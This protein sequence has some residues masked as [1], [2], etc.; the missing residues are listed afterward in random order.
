M[1]AVAI[2]VVLLESFYWAGLTAAGRE[3]HPL[4]RS[5]EYL[6][7]IAALAVS[8]AT[9]VFGTLQGWRYFRTGESWSKT[10]SWIGMISLLMNVSWIL[11]LLG[12]V[13]AKVF[14]LWYSG[15]S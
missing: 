7:N 3:A 6:I 2:A 13:T 8:I 14:I 5:I 10:K 4:G 12:F 11:L 1:F 15:S 9:A